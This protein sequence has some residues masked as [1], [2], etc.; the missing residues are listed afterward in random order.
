[1]WK[2]NWD[3]SLGGFWSRPREK[4]VPEVKRWD[5]YKREIKIAYQHQLERAH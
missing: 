3:S 5:G 4:E 2:M 1:M